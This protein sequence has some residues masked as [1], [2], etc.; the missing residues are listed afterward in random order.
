MRKALGLVCLLALIVGGTV[1]CS[2]QKS[3]WIHAWHNTPARPYSAQPR[4]AVAIRTSPGGE[5]MPLRGTAGQ[6]EE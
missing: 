5:T 1:S 6:Q 3:R 2:D 4:A